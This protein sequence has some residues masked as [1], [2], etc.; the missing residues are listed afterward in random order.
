[1]RSKTLV[2]ALLVSAVLAGCST[3][4]SM[5][6]R[7]KGT[8]IGAGAG[9]VVGNAVGGGTVG[10]VGGAVV[11]GAAGRYLGREQ[12]EKQRQEEADRAKNK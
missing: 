5:S 4:D 8:A 3:W 11:G 7:D 2:A 10:T 1:M 9:A 12:E 6:K